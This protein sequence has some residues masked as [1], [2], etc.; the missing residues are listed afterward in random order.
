MSR[1]HYF[2]RYSSVE[3]TV[4]NNTLQ[5]FGRIYEYSARAAS[6]L[7]S[8]L[9]D[10]AIYIGIEITQQNRSSTSVPDGT[11]IQ[12][13]FKIAIEAKVDAP[14][15]FDQLT[16]HV[17]SFGTEAQRILLLL[18]KAPLAA[19]EE[20]ELVKLQEKFPGVVI[21][22]ITFEQICDAIKLLFK[23]HEETIIEL[24]DDYIEYCND[25]GL[26]D[27]S[28]ELM[29]IVPCGQ[30]VEINQMHGIYFQPSDR[31]YTNH[32]FVGIYNQKSVR[33]VLEVKSVFDVEL[34]GDN[35]KKELVQGENTSAYDGS[36]R[37]IIADAKTRC[38]YDIESGHRFFCGKMVSTNYQKV[39]PGGIQGARFVN[40]REVLGPYGDVDDIASKLSNATWE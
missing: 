35:L 3:N 16:R 18:T 2:Q 17:S 32:A 14:V 25:T 31:G 22:S 27:Q 26:F 38:D 9:T 10:E 8:E 30:S 37:A 11:I 34:N 39:S 24:A 20:V 4:T 29:R 40:L 5:L 1:I 13:S 6:R 21:R 36:I 33:A 12:S 19:N 15:D 7:L 28:R 23:P